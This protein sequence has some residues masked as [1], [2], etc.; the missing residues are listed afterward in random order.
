MVSNGLPWNGLAGEAGRLVRNQQ[1]YGHRCSPRPQTA[2]IVNHN[3]L[4][5]KLRY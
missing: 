3:G 4:D 2:L 1:G 5:T